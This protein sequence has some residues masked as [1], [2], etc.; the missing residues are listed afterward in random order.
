MTVKPAGTFLD[1]VSSLF[2]KVLQHMREPYNMPERFDEWVHNLPLNLD[3]DCSLDDMDFYSGP[4]EDIWKKFDIGIPAD[5]PNYEEQCEIWDTYGSFSSSFQLNSCSVAGE[6]RNHD[7]MWAGHCLSIEHKRTNSPT[8]PHLVQPIQMVK[9]STAVNNNSVLI[10]SQ[11]LVTVQKSV[12][13]SPSPV[14]PAPSVKCDR[15]NGSDSATT[16]I[17]TNNG[18]T[19]VI[20]Q[21]TVGRS[22][23]LNSR[24]NNNNNSSSSIIN[25]TI[26]NNNNNNNNN[27]SNHNN[28]S[29]AAVKQ[30]CVIPHRRSRESNGDSPRPETPQSLSGDD[31]YPIPI[32]HNNSTT[33]FRNALD[34]MLSQTAVPDDWEE[35]LLMNF[36]DVKRTKQNTTPV[37]TQP[38]ADLSRIS[39]SAQIDHNYDGSNKIRTEGL[40]VQTPSDSE[41]EEIDVVSLSERTSNSRS[42]STSSS[43][44]STSG[45]PTKPSLA[46]QKQLQEITTSKLLSAS[47]A[48]SRKLKFTTT[49]YETNVNVQG[50]RKKSDS[51]TEDEGTGYTKI[52]RQ[53]KKAKNHSTRRKYRSRF[54]TDSEPDSRE[55]RS[56]HNSMERMRRIDLRNSF[57]ELRQLVPSLSN[58]DRAA[59]VVILRDAAVYCSDLGTQSRL[60]KN[61]V[62]ALQREQ[63]RLRS[64]V[65]SLR[66]A[67]AVCVKQQAHKKKKSFKSK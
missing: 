3:D 29:T 9:P 53:N 6:I 19:G 16:S 27:N 33:I 10:N 38:H 55:K 30:E 66:K 8:P 58:K 63:L 35:E 20:V 40:G 37:H 62:E 48:V 12:P 56:L 46:D 67:A 41:E 22:L 52:S 5:F 64:V 49:K 36:G 34:V 17:I 43:G 7:C 42:S 45:L 21:R 14:K 2:N 4:T 26:N 39:A 24:T 15:R 61:E 32:D 50:K 54:S 44:G 23:L 11:K 31:E 60:M 18:R 57:E 47:K 1:T 13:Y 25:N 59:K 65:S 51:T 28:Q